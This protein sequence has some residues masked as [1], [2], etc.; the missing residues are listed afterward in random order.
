M[1]GNLTW[2]P[3]PLDALN[4][5]KHCAAFGSMTRGKLDGFNP[6]ADLN[7]AVMFLSSTLPSDFQPLPDNVQLIRWYLRLLFASGAD[8]EN[9]GRKIQDAALVCHDRFCTFTGLYGNSDVAGVGVSFFRLA[10]TSAESRFG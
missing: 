2:T 3:P 1:A 10:S 5:T 8:Q 7:M 9:L 6:N 4:F